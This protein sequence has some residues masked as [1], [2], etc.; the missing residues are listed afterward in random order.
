LNDAESEINDFDHVGLLFNQNIVQLN[1]P[2]RYILSVQVFHTLC[3][4]LKHS[5]TLG[6][7][8]FPSG[9]PYVFDV[10][11]EGNAIDEVSYQIDLPLCVHQFMHPNYIRMI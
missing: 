6:L 3:Y 4:L 1:V 7:I 2:V 10:L 5:P 11:L 8:D 9:T